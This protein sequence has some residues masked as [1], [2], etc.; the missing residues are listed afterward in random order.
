M[1]P[2]EKIIELIKNSNENDTVIIHPNRTYHYSELQTVSIHFSRY[3]I[4]NGNKLQGS[5]EEIFD[6]W[7][8]EFSAENYK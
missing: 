2:T 6:K 5:P 7:F 4:E 3:V 8:E 1:K